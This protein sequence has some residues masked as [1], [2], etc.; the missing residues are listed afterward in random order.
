[1]PIVLPDHSASGARSSNDTNTTVLSKPKQLSEAEA[2]RMLNPNTHSVEQLIEACVQQESRDRVS[3]A[4]VAAERVRRA[5]EEEDR[6]AAEV[7]RYKDLLKVAA[8]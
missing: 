4:R 7:A 6:K 2:Q 1:M 5:K 3:Q 8:S